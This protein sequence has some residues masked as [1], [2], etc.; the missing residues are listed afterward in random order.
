M[1]SNPLAKKA[2]K[3]G[4]RLAE[5]QAAE[6]SIMHQ[7]RNANLEWKTALATSDADRGAVAAL[8]SRLRDQQY[9]TAELERQ[10]AEVQA[11]IDAAERAKAA[12]A[13]YA[14][15]STRLTAAKSAHDAA[16]GRANGGLDRFAEQIGILVTGLLESI[17]SEQRARSEFADALAAFNDAAGA[18]GKPGEAIE[19]CTPDLLDR[20]ILAQPVPGTPLDIAMQRTL[21]AV[22]RADAVAV[23]TEVPRVALWCASTDRVAEGAE[24]QERQKRA[25]E[26]SVK[27]AAERQAERDKA[28]A[29][30]KAR[31]SFLAGRVDTRPGW[32]GR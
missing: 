14:A 21:I 19:V 27:A 17:E 24:Q 11:E 20:K 31:R 10:R 2:E 32:A 12:A 7:L 28:V 4:Q 13:E 23:L 15:A 25:E 8:E 29:D 26:A 18:V 16:F 5:S 9:V 30:E 1:R 6:A 22:Q 3:L